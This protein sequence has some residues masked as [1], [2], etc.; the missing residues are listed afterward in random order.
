MSGHKALSRFL[1]DVQ[2]LQTADIER[3]IP[4]WT[5][6]FI[7]SVERIRPGSVIPLFNQD[8]PISEG[9]KSL[10]NDFELRAN[11][12]SCLDGLDDDP[13]AYVSMSIYEPVRPISRLLPKFVP[14]ANI[15]VIAVMHD[16]VPHLFPD[17]YGYSDFD[18]RLNRARESLFR[19]AD[20]F[21]CNSLNTAKDTIDCLGVN[22]H[23]VHVVGSGIEAIFSQ[24][25]PD[26]ALLSRLGVKS[27]FVLTVGRADPRKQTLRLIEAYSQLPHSLRN[28]HSLV[29]A[30][31]LDEKTEAVWR[32][33]IEQLG[34]HPDQVLL[35]GLVT[36]DELRALYSAAEL[37]VEPSLYEGFGF[38]AAEAAACGSVAIT[39][40]SSSLPE[41]LDDSSALF[42]ASDLDDMVRLMVVGL[43]D[44]SFREARLK[45]N[46]NILRR[47]N[48]GDVAARAIKVM[49]SVA[50]VATTHSA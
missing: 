50:R 31:R 4:R 24:Q 26:P 30:C 6:N 28:S 19:G 41:V 8:L 3:G 22:A 17:L 45:R 32:T 15:P 43:S 7:R 47:H 25:I 34:L 48:W 38:P 5:N 18:R 49:D 39:A 14:N 36:D 12:P 27:S 16:L 13:L 40:D 2:C 9:L 21:L 37:F 20:G 46:S 10:E 1:V 29:I 35:T 33:R 11:A 44:E 42:S 23:R